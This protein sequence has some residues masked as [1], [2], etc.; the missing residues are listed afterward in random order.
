MELFLRIVA[1]VSLLIGSIVSFFYVRLAYKREKKKD[2]VWETALQIIQNSG[3]ALS[4]AEDFAK[5]YIVLS[6]FR[7]DPSAVPD[8]NRLFTHR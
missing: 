5:L 7:K 4:T 8:P 6:D 2:V 1:A 3:T